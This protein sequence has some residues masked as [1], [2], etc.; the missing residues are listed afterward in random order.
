MT[1]FRENQLTVELTKL[2]RD[3]ASASRELAE[4]RNNLNVRSAEHMRAKDAL[5]RWLFE[6]IGEDDDGGADG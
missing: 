6:N 2:Y 5:K 4:A 1:K 3:Y